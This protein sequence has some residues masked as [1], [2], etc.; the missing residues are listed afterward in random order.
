MPTLDG[1]DQPWP[2]SA[3][4]PS[5][6]AAHGQ[7]ADPDSPPI[8]VLIVDDTADVRLLVRLL[9]SERPNL[10][11]VAEAADGAA[12]IDLAA[13]LKPDLIVL[14]IAMPI[15]DG[16]EALPRLREASPESRVVMLSAVPRDS[17]GSAALAAGAAAYV[18]KS[19]ATDAMVDE[20][21]AGA[22]LLD[23]AVRALTTAARENF[24]ADPQS[25]SAAR[26]FVSGTLSQWNLTDLADT[27]TLLLSELVTNAIVHA[28]AAP[29]VTVRL[30]PDRVHVEVA[31]SRPDVVHAQEPPDTAQS[32]RGLVL[33]DALA[34]SWGSV[35]LPQG[36][37]VWFDVARE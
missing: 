22:G 33:V 2:E 6:N 7:K 1:R 34:A 28:E 15:M 31:D 27:I 35:A 9:V 20:L 32:G 18:E 19:V 37:V 10:E 25:V 30:L 12:A 24:A 11:V 5:P 3:G 26:R 36:K 29:D 16:L 8:R 17:H 21:L 4:R 23:A 13:A 14:D